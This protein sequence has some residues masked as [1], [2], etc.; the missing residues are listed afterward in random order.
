MQTQCLLAAQTALE[1]TDA[2]SFV[3]SILNNDLINASQ[4]FILAQANTTAQTTLDLLTD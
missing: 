4:L 1:T 3:L 2:A